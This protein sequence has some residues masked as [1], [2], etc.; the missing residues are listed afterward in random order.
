MRQAGDPQGVC[1][2]MSTQRWKTSP[3]GRNPYTEVTQVHGTTEAMV[4]PGVA[5]EV[6]RA[7]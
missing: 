7:M 5:Q 6:G 2:V 3:N 4:T 1:R